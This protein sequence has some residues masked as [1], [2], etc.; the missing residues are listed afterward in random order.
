MKKELLLIIFFII[1]SSCSKNIIYRKPVVGFVKNINNRPLSN[2][3]IYYDSLDVLSPRNIISK[4]NGYFLLPKIEIENSQ[5]SKRKIQKLNSFIFF[6]KNGYKTK[7]INLSTFKN[8]D[9]IKLGV[10]NLEEL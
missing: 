5:E 3:H 8:S 7:K 9:T 1:N 2:V 6:K 4:N 10:V